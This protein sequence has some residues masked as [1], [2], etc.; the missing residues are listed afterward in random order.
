[1]F[2]PIKGSMLQPAPLTVETIVRATPFPAEPPSEALHWTDEEWQE[3]RG[4]WEKFTGPVRDLGHFAL[5]VTYKRAEGANTLI[6]Y[7][8]GELIVDMISDDDLE[9]FAPLLT[10]V[11]PVFQIKA[12]TKTPRNQP[13]PCGSGKKFKKCCE[14]FS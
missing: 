9:D 12:E 4:A 1:M 6:E 10:T 7:R 11:N 3:L 2:Q 5:A 8:H 13:C 14:R